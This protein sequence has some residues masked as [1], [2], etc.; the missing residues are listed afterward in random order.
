LHVGA[1]TRQIEEQPPQQSAGI[2]SIL[3]P[4]HMHTQLTHTHIHRAC[5]QLTQPIETH[6]H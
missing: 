2:S 4:A 5:P 1:I 3:W 6:T